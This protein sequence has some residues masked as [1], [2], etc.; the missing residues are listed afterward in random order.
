LYV[1]PDFE[2]EGLFFS[3]EGGKDFEL[4]EPDVRALHQ[5]LWRWLNDYA[6]QRRGDT[7]PPDGG[8]LRFVP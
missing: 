2:S 6:M 5:R 4:T 7:Q 8:D 1:S 3:L